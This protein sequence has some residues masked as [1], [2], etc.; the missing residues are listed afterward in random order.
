MPAFSPPACAQPLEGERPHLLHA[1]LALELLD[2]EAQRRVER[3]QLH[4]L[5]EQGDPLV[6]EAVL[7]VLLGDEAVFVHR[8][9]ELPELGVDLGEL[10]VGV[11][12]VG[13]VLE[14]RAQALP[15][16]VVPL[17]DEEVVD[18]VFLRLRL[19]LAAAEPV[20]RQGLLRHNGPRSSKPKLVSSLPAGTAV[21]PGVDTAADE[22][23]H[24]SGEGR[25]GKWAKRL[26]KRRLAAPAGGLAGKT[27][28][29]PEVALF[30]GEGIVRLMETRQ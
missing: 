17:E 2:L 15:R 28:D 1:L 4:R 22:S 6:V 19:F 23:A 10:E 26:K 16:L 30:S 9:L 27:D 25:R 20:D 11:Q 8:L 3:G 14:A 24:Y 12:I 21:T 13:I 5:G 18:R 7:G 29:G